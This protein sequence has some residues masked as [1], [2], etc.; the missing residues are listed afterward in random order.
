M[1]GPHAERTAAMRQRL[2]EA[3]IA[4]LYEL[5]YAATTFQVVTDR[6]EVSRGAILHHFPTKVDLMVA[7]AEYAALYQ[8]RVIRERLADTPAGMSLY[9]ALTYATWEIVIQPPAMALI[10]VM[11]A[12]RADAALAERLP[13]VVTAFEARQ[14]EDVWRLAQRIGIRDREQVDTMVRLHRA[15]M[16]GL[17]IELSLTGDRA[18]A[19]A[20][21]RL[22]ERYKRMLTGELVTAID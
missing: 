22:L 16:R 2:I 9:L 20:S 19:E 14:R 5:G 15:A 21:M 10:E 13:A 4:C 7:V 18:A 12:T 6:A 3:A 11:M 17:A 8:N 1:R